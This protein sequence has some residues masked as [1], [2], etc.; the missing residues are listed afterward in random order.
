MRFYVKKIDILLQNLSQ[1][2]SQQDMTLK[3]RIHKMSI[4]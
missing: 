1:L 2:T 4:L 3:H